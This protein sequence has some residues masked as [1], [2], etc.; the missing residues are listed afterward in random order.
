MRAA[1]P[2]MRSSE[3][4]SFHLFLAIDQARAFILLLA[5]SLIC[6]FAQAQSVTFTG[7]ITEI[8]DPSGAVQ[9]EMVEQADVEGSFTLHEATSTLVSSE[10]RVASRNYGSQSRLQLRIGHHLLRSNSSE[11]KTVVEF[12]GKS[13]HPVRHSV[14]RNQLLLSATG[15]Q[16]TSRQS[17]AI[18]IHSV[19]LQ[20][21]SDA[22]PAAVRRSSTTS[23]PTKLSDLASQSLSTWQAPYGLILR[24]TISGGD[25]TEFII[26]VQLSSVQVTT[27]T[28]TRP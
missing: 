11:G 8:L 20:L 26:R 3:A 13:E 15:L 23:L 27:T 25:D 18:Q 19:E 7:K 5:F 22:S 16:W 2:L 12:A 21:E 10:N 24:G 6:G 14:N 9:A 17:S 4:G 1:N 28:T